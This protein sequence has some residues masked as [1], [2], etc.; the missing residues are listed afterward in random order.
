MTMLTELTRSSCFAP[1]MENGEVCDHLKRILLVNAEIRFQVLYEP[2][3]ADFDSTVRVDRHFNEWP[4][5]QLVP[6]V[7]TRDDVQSALLAVRPTV[8]QE[9]MLEY[10]RWADQF[11]VGSV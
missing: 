4:A 11:G 2:C 5:A 9:D 3:A 7:V 1:V 6:R 10:G 8:T